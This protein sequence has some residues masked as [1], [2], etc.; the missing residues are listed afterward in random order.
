MNTEPLDFFENKEKAIYHALWLNFKY[1][2]AGIN[3]GV[4]IAPDNNFTVVEEATAKEL[5]A[6]FLEIPSNYEKM[7]FDEIRH[8]RM[9][10]N[11]LPHL[12]EII[13][14]FSVMDGELLRYILHSKIPLEKLIRYELAI[15]GYDKNHR[16]CGFAKAEKIW[17]ENE[18]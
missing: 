15:R 17:L 9:D 5:S 7:N 1:R 18:Q 4:I 3:F 2:I 16:W 14:I 13:G 12:S 11:P 6:E 10:K 8:I